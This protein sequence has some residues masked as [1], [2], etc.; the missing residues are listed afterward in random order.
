MFDDDDDTLILLE[1]RSVYD[2]MI[3]GMS[4]EGVLVYDK[5]KIIAYHATLSD[6]P[7]EEDKHLEAVEH[8]YYN[9]QPSQHPK[10]PTFVSKDDLL[11]TLDQLGV[12][13]KTSEIN[14]D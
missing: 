9:I 6:E 13:L 10:Y 7:L 4:E 14:I 2:P 12:E 5:D 11:N 8:F 3:V 1:P